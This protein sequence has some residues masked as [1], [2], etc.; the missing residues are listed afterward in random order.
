MLL[1]IVA[2]ALVL[3]AGSA[4]AQLAPP[5]MPYGGEEDLETLLISKKQ[6]TL[7]MRV[8]ACYSASDLIETLSADEGGRELVVTEL[9]K[10]KRCL[11]LDRIPMQALALQGRT[12]PDRKHVCIV[13]MR[14][15]SPGKYA[16]RK[17]K[18]APTE[19]DRQLLEV[20]NGKTVYIAWS[21]SSRMIYDNCGVR[22]I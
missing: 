19:A 10:L 7:P 11:L 9:T 4:Q 14:S 1:R 16:L 18:K 6:L 8:L 13:H 2:L 3:L 21:V 12:L 20:L 15:A 5:L 17:G 22:A